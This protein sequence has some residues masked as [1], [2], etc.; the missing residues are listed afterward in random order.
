MVSSMFSMNPYFTI[1]GHGRYVPQ[2]LVTAEEIDQTLSLPPGW[3]FRHTGVQTRYVAAPAESNADMG[4]VAL[5]RALEVA[6]LQP[7]DLDL[8]VCASGSF[9]Q[10]I[11]FNACLLM[12]RLGWEQYPIASFDIDATCLSF[13]VALDVV[14]GLLMA[15]RYQRV[16]IVTS[17]IASRSLNAKD[18]KTYGLFGDAAAAIILEH[19]KAET[20]L[21]VTHR[22]FETHAGG[23]SMVRVPGGGNAQHPRHHPF[24]DEDYCF[25]MD[26]F[27]LLRFTLPRFDQ[28][29]G[30]FLHKAQL[31]PNNFD[32]V[33][34]H[35]VSRV[36]LDH[37][38]KTYDLA[39]ENIWAN[40]D[41]YGNCIAA[42]LPLSLSEA[43]EAGR[44]KPG[45]RVLLLGTAAGVSLG[46]MVIE[47]H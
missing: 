25:Q 35:Q 36:G 19:S 5:Q 40:L 46:A 27:D 29:F 16:A 34:A 45:G 14:T 6:R 43:I 1:A 32:L 33:I 38:M 13:L 42:S 20:G 17:E 8:I 22:K 7:T 39:P 26:A 2:N 30:D 4:A 9:D 31:A 44:L 15:G 37:L 11:P 12:Q 21:T 47:S 24:R 23:A 10:P 41:R 3:T 28:F 18:P